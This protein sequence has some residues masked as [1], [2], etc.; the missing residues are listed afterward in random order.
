MSKGMESIKKVEEAEAKAKELVE[1]AN[2]NAKR[3]L[4]DANAEAKAII[5][6]AGTKAKAEKMSRMEKKA[7]ELEGRRV[8]GLEALHAEAEKLKKVKVSNQV[9]EKV[10]KKAAETILGA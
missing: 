2:E 1:K 6:D 9:L 4:G 10:S 3:I 8:K 5:D 7:A